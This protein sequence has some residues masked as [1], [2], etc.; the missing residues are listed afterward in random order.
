MNRPNINDYLLVPNVKAS[1][2][3]QYYYDL[4]KYCDFLEKKLGIKGWVKKLPCKCGH[5]GKCTRIKKYNEYD[6]V[7][8]YGLKCKKCG[9]EVWDD[10]NNRYRDRQLNILWNEAV[11]NEGD[12]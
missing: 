8:A 3:R 2:K 12:R 6:H 10:F 11:K 1:V 5:T 7:I 9:F 4:E